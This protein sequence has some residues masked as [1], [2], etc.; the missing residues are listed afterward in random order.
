VS[1]TPPALTVG[2]MQVTS[3][4]PMLARAELR[5]RERVRRVASRE[6]GLP[7]AGYYERIWDSFEGLET[8]VMP[9]ALGECVFR[10]GGKSTTVETALARQAVRGDRRFALYVSSTQEAAN[11]HVQAVDALRLWARPRATG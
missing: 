4:L 5:W 3:T 8:V 9:A 7:T 2:A 11:R 6:V 1:K 10:G